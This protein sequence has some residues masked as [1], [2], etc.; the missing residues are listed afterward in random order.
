MHLGTWTPSHSC[1]SASVINAAVAAAATA[2]SAVLFMN[3][4]LKLLL[5]VGAASQGSG[6]LSWAF[7]GFWVLLGLGF[8]GEVVLDA[9][10][11]HI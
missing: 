10:V 2:G 1:F 3:I 7:L 11:L 4:S 5:N 9:R 8:G 6:P